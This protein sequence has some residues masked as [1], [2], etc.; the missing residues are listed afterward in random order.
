MFGGCPITFDCSLPHC[1]CFQRPSNR[2]P[3]NIPHLRLFARLP[4]DAMYKAD[5]AN[6]YIEDV[7]TLYGISLPPGKLAFLAPAHEVNSVSFF[8]EILP[9]HLPGNCIAVQR[10]LLLMLCV[11]YYR[12]LRC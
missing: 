6:K 12:P 8:S 3:F 11:S 7:I 9:E 10:H 1:C 5:A 4:A 2:F